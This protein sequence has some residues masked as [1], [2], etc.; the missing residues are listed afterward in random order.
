MVYSASDLKISVQE[1]NLADANCLMVK[2]NHTTMLLAIYRPPAKKDLSNFLDSLDKILQEIGHYSNIIIS[3]DLNINICEDHHDSNKCNYLSLLAFHGL[4]PA[5]TL[6]TRLDSCLDHLFLKT[7]LKAITFVAH[8][9]LTDHD[10]VL[11]FLANKKERPTINSFVTNIDYDKINSDLSTLDFTPLYELKNPNDAASLLISLLRQVIEN[12]TR[13]VKMSRRKKIIKPWITPGLLRCIVHR[14]KLHKNVKLNP[15]N[16][17]LRKSYTR[18][19]NHCN[20]LLKNVKSEYEKNLI[21]SAGSNGKKIWEAIN[22]ITNRNKIKQNSSQLLT[23]SNSPIEAVENINS[24]FVNVGTCLAEKILNKPREPSAKSIECPCPYSMGL[25]P[26]D[27]VE[28]ESLIINLRQNCAMGW[29]GISSEFLKKYKD[30]LVSPLTFVCNLALEM[31]IFP[32]AFKTAII[33]PI[34]KSGDRNI[35]TNYRPIAILSSMSKVLEKVMNNRLVKYLETNNLLSP[36]Q[37]GF[38]AGKST[39]D[40]VDS[41]TN[42]IATELDKKHKVIGIFLDLA[43]AFDTVSVPT[44]VKKLE[45]MGIRGL[46]L[47]LYENYLCGRKQS[48]KLD[49]YTSCE[50]MTTYGVPQGSVLGPTLFLIYINDLCAIALPKTKIITYADDTA[51]L[52]SGSSWSE[53]FYNAQN[54]LNIITKWLHDNLLTLNVDKTKYI[55]FSIKDLNSEIL[56]SYSLF[57]HSCPY[58]YNSTCC[59]TAIERTKTL[60]YL[61]IILDNTLNFKTHIN[62]LSNRLR[63]I[64]YVF[65]SLRHV[66]DRDLIKK[67]YFALCQSLLNYCIVS[68]GGGPKSTLMPLER[69]QRAILKVSSFLPF[70]FPT[71][72]LYLDYEVL[73][74]RKLYILQTLLMQHSLSDYVPACEQIP[75]RRHN[76]INRLQ[77]KFTTTFAQKFFCFRGNYLYNKINNKTNIYHLP[78]Q[79]CKTKIT[80]WLLTL[81]Y[82]DT[83]NLITIPT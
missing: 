48:V 35:V 56:A 51:I 8:S 24:F 64:I 54:A 6:K 73:T 59:C 20:E 62:A 34:Y 47:N 80:N 65:R 37:Y 58:P 41:L 12:N 69:T 4:L 14:D 44:L 43:K 72:D 55:A 66:A 42:H 28:I 32:T 78:K 75:H 17:I 70:R 30:V 15:N 36:C 11:L 49:R 77:F 27:E 33:H 13:K 16:D 7:H 1:P 63:K 25:L 31:G 81:N 19:R 46:Q 68:W 29:D 22:N 50:K 40:A 76:P 23:A 79:L 82:E 3:G 57:G 18:Y 10:T 74:V 9:S 53:T 67:V 21:K 60:K 61:G 26:T 52:V 71:T 2:I 5:H 38:R 45:G 39:S 83:E